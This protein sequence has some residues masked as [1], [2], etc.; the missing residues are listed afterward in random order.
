MADG[1]SLRECLLESVDDLDAVVKQVTFYCCYS[2][3]N[4]LLQLLN[5]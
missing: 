5:R 1:R 3:G 4:S 2:V